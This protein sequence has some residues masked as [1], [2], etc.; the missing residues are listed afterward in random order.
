MD[1]PPTEVIVISDSEEEAQ[2]Q[3]E[4]ELPGVEDLVSVLEGERP[5]EEGK[6]NGA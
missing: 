4:V 2:G 3:G 1:P 6:A 5:L